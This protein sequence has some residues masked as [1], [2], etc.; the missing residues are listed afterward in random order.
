MIAKEGSLRENDFCDK[1]IELRGMGEKL[2]T[3]I[4][5]L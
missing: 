1:V 4:H 2:K 3:I 5:R